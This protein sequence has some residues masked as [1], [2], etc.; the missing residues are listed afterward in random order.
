MWTSL[1]Q[2]ALLILTDLLE[3]FL[4]LQGSCAAM[5]SVAPPAAARRSDFLQLRMGIPVTK[6]LL[7][8]PFVPKIC[9]EARG[10]NQVYKM[11][12]REPCETE[13]HQTIDQETP[14]NVKFTGRLRVGWG[15]L[16]LLHLFLPRVLHHLVPAW[17]LY[18]W[19][20]KHSRA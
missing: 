2:L 5:P 9:A 19:R 11:I 20:R 18:R 14:L 7:S 4:M 12:A 6:Q 16:R 15:S 13:A 10:Q 1:V 17:I 3:I 8:D